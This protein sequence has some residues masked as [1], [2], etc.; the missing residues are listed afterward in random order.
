MKQFIIAVA[1][2]MQPG[3]SIMATLKGPTRNMYKTEKMRT[4]TFYNF[5]S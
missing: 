4:V 2:V 1:R 5:G 3:S